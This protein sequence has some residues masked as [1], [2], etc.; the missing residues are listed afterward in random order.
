MQRPRP[1]RPLSYSR[2]S[3]EAFLEA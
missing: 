2:S 3:E 1:P